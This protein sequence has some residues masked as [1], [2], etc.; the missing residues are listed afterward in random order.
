MLA[1]IGARMSYVWLTGAG[2]LTI[3]DFI[4]GHYQYGI[5]VLILAYH[6]ETM[7]YSNNV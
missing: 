5:I 1:F 2:G 7:Q 6:Y 4:Q 3:M